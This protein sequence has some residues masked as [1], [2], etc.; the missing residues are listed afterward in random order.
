MKSRLNETEEPHNQFTGPPAFDGFG[1]FY[2]PAFGNVEPG[3]K[4][5][6]VLVA[7]LSIIG[8]GSILLVTLGS[9]SW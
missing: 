2:D 8:V 9:N 3:A 6:W 1:G 5:T 4:A 7:V